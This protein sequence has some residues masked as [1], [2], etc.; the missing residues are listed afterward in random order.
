MR[1]LLRVAVLVIATA[2]VVGA[3]VVGARMLLEQA[4]EG[5]SVDVSGPPAVDCA[6]QPDRGRAAMARDRF[7]HQH[8]QGSGQ[9]WFEGAA[10]A[11]ARTGRDRLASEAPSTDPGALVGDGWVLVVSYDP[12]ASLPQALPGCIASTPVLYLPATEPS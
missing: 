9:R 11:D 2:L 6:P 7:R 12:E 3:G 10:L 1:R 5:E 4:D 8:V